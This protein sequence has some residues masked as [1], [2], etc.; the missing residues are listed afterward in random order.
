MKLVKDL[1]LQLKLKKL[2]MQLNLSMLTPYQL[3]L[4]QVTLLFQILKSI[5]KILKQKF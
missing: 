1:K 4:D 5:L 2:K 3:M